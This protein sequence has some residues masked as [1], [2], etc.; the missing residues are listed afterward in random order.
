MIVQFFLSPCDM[1]L[2]GK[3]VIVVPYCLLKFFFLKSKN[4]LDAV[5]STDLGAQHCFKFRIRQL[6]SVNNTKIIWLIGS[7]LFSVV[8]VV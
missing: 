2:Y 1:L 4:V 3:L 8:F 7:R 5:L 6:I